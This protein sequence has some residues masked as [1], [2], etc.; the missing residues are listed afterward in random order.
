MPKLGFEYDAFDVRWAQQLTTTNDYEPLAHFARITSL[1]SVVQATA[2]IC[3]PSHTVL[4]SPELF[5]RNYLGPPPDIFFDDDLVQSRALIRPCIILMP[6]GDTS[7]ATSRATIF[8]ITIL[9]H[10]HHPHPRQSTSYLRVLT[11]NIAIDDPDTI[12]TMKCP[13]STLLP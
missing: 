4:P 11:D 7:V 13:Q 9:G 10:R 8:R 2:V 12:T 1:A 5:H 6:Q 3:V